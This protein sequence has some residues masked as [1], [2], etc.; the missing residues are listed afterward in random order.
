MAAAEQ[1]AII[2]GIDKRL[3]QVNRSHFTILHFHHSDILTGTISE[4]VY[5]VGS[6]LQIHPSI[7]N[8]ASKAHHDGTAK[9]FFQ[10]S[11]FDQ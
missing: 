9:W 7:I 8:T 1:T 3:E 6:H 5:S 4:M 11:I 10:G 2:R